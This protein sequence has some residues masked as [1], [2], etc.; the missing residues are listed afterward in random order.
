MKS[1]AKATR[2]RPNH[3]TRQIPRTRTAAASEMVRLEFER[4]RLMR[5]K[6]VMTDRMAVTDLTL[7]RVN[8]RIA[9]LQEMMRIDPSITN[10]SRKGGR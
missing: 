9:S 3:V 10:S 8:T 6:A 2:P 7:G 5:D 1:A 4:D